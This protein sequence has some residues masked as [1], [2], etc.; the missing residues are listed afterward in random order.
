[1]MIDVPKPFYFGVRSCGCHTATMVDD[2]E[3]TAAHVADFAKRMA[4]SGRRV[5]HKSVTRAEF[6]ALAD[7]CCAECKERRAALAA[8]GKHE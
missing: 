1:M 8:G 5:V 7:Q 3:T 6:M 4:K 2:E